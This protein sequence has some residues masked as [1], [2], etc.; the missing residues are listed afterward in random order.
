[1]KVPEVPVVPAVPMVPVVPGVPVVPVVRRVPCAWL[2]GAVLLAAPAGAQSFE[3][4]LQSAAGTSGV[5]WVGYR[6]PM[7]AGDHRICCDGCR[8]E[9]GRNMTMST[10][11]LLEPP[12]ELLVLARFEN[13]S[14]TRLRTFTPDCD[15]DATGTTLTWLTNATADDSIAWLSSVVSRAQNESRNRLIDPALSALAF[16]AG[17]RATAA[18]VGFARTHASTHVRAQALFWLAQR[19]GQQALATIANAVDNDPETDVKRRAVFALS[20]LPKDE[21]VPK[22]IEVARNHR[23]PEVRKQAFFWLGQSKDPRA[24]QFF[25]E[26]LLKK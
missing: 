5:T 16:E 22:L 23:N 20:Q 17:D 18:L 4:R 1:M 25:E 9:N 7:I 26:I 6:V 19:A 3:Q 2:L 11:V 10:R 15:L 24:V 14:L 21:G 13:R 12:R 8:L